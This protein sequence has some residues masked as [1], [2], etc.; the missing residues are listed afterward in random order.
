VRY[1]I[2]ACAAIV[3]SVVSLYAPAGG[4]WFFE[5]DLQWLAGTLTFEPGHLLDVSS[6]NHFYRPVIALY[7]WAATPLFKGSPAL[8]HWANILLH[9]ANALLVLLIARAIGLRMRS[10]F[11]AAMFF[12]SMPAY[13]EAIAWVS[14]LAEAVTTFFGGI[15]LYGALRGRRD[16]SSAWRALSVVSFAAALMTHESAAILLPLLVIADRAF[17]RDEEQRR[18]GWLRRLRFFIPHAMLLGVY[19]LVDASINQRSYLV[20]EGHYRI[21]WHAIENLLG[22]VVA[23]YVGKRNLPTYVFV[24]ATLVLLLL[25]GSPRVVFATSWLVLT[26]LPFAFFTW[27]NTSRYAYTPAVGLALL[28]AEGFEWLESRLGRVLTRRA[29]AAAAAVLA[30]FITARFGMFAFRAVNNFSHRT[31]PYRAYAATVRQ[32]YPDPQPGSS[33]T[34]DPRTS[35]T[36]HHRYLEALVRWEFQDPTLA[37][38]LEP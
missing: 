7:F 32:T 30:L 21:G 14:A 22:Y 18:S 17:V 38:V 9:A 33:I 35:P 28:L 34:L 29:A 25:R 8:F 27:G 23:L 2:A 1:V 4:A 6:Q 20:E 13:V 3:L 36:P 5:D 24:S 31:E 12:L 10:A 11:A 26:I 19:L 37:V 16:G 15:A